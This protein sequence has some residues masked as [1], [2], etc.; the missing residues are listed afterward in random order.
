MAG[1]DAYDRRMPT[2]ASVLP[3]DLLNDLARGDAEA[4]QM[5][6]NLESED[7]LDAT[8]LDDF[9]GG[10]TTGGPPAARVKAGSRA[11]QRRLE[12]NA[13]PAAALSATW[14]LFVQKER[15]RQVAA[16]DFAP[17]PGALVFAVR[18]DFYEVAPGRPKSKYVTPYLPADSTT[19]VVELGLGHWNGNEEVFHIGVPITPATP[20]WIPSVCDSDAAWYWRRPPPS[21]AEDWGMTWH[22]ADCRPAQPELLVTLSPADHVPPTALAGLTTPPV[23]DCL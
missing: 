19:L 17:E 13:G 5:L 8:D 4:R 21:H 2:A 10:I 3:A 15:L 14:H 18:G 20:V 9:R 23:T 11:C 22:M 16:S 12:K 6:R 1:A 7:R